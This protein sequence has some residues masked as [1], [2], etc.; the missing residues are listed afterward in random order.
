MIDWTDLRYFAA[1]SRA[2]SLAGAARAL[3]VN[4]STVFRRINSLESTLAVKLFERGR[5]G[6]VLTAEG[7][8]MMATALGVEESITALDR[9]MA[10]KDYRL[11]GSI[12]VTT[13]E[14]IA[15]TLLEPHLRDFH[16]AYP[17]IQVE[18]VISNEF[19]SLSKRDADIALRPTRN[20]PE[21]L[22]GRRLAGLAW[23][24][25]GATRYLAHRSRPRR[26]ADLAK[27]DH[28][29][30]DDS[31]SHLEVTRW[32]RRRVPD[33]RIVLR[34]N[35]VAALCGAARAGLG[36]AVLPCFLADPHTDLVRVLGPVAEL[37]SELWLLTHG[38]LRHTA[39][40]RAF[41]EFVGQSVAGDR[42]LLEGRRPRRAS[43]ADGIGSRRGGE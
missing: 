40:V 32:L 8:E 27:H 2:G 7:E 22:V 19:F 26:T 18:L 24:V 4:H 34:S 1:V 33:A 9:R 5:D 11:S 3:G 13:T 6:Y 39:R 38:D 42:P 31:L 25:Y 36:L 15:S 10:G 43:A 35:S 28:V 29:A 41:M 30:G 37:D 14:T 17:G 23:A 21:E 20:P 12:R 16:E